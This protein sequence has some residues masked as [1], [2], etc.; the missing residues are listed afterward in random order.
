MVK[1]DS[2]FIPLMTFKYPNEKYGAYIYKNGFTSTWKIFG[3]P[4]WVTPLSKN[5][6][7]KFNNQKS[8]LLPIR[9]PIDRFISGINTIHKYEEYKNQSV[10]DIIK[11]LET[12]IFNK[13][14]LIN[15]ST[16]LINAK[17]YFDNLYLYKF[18]EHYREMLSDGGYDGEIPHENIS[19]SKVVLTQSQ[20]ER[21]KN[22]YAK[23]IEIFESIKNSG[24][25]FNFPKMQ[26]IAKTQKTS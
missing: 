25:L 18:P 10:D 19:T 17:L 8:L 20:L 5:K 16:I 12:D 24:Q 6:I 23:D 9:N 1:T 15:V 3:K 13:L 26:P 2:K 4:F 11:M 14:D 7:V 21:V 22:I